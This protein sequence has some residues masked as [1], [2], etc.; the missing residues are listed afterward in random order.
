MKKLFFFAAVALIA[1]GG[2]ANAALYITGTDT[3]I[4]CD[5]PASTTCEIVTGYPSS[6]QLSSI[7]V[8]Q[9]GQTNDKGTVAD[10]SYTGI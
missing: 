1:V 10:Y 5:V 2:A 4:L 9:G 6:T 7:P 8:S 3:Q